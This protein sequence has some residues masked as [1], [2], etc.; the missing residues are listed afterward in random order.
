MDVV[1][2]K[3]KGNNELINFSTFEKIFEIGTEDEFYDRVVSH[4]KID[5][6][7]NREHLIL[8]FT[9]R[10]SG[11]DTRVYH[12]NTYDNQGNHIERVIGLRQ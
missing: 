3:E 5:T 10:I 4:F 12:L 8:F 2:F 11:K 9:Q 1:E 6:S 7:I